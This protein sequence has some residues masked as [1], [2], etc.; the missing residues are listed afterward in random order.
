MFG[1]EKEK[2]MKYIGSNEKTELKNG[3]IYPVVIEHH[4]FSKRLTA[5]IFLP[6]TEQVITRLY[7]NRYYLSLN[8]KGEE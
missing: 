1:V 3:E 2:K 5:W 6:Q 4:F 8:W 7:K